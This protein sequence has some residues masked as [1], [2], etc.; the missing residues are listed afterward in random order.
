MLEM[1]QLMPAY[2]SWIRFIPRSFAFPGVEWV[3]PDSTL[4]MGEAWVRELGNWGVPTSDGS[5]PWISRKPVP[6]KL[7]ALRQALELYVLGLYQS[8]T[9]ADS[10]KSDVHPR[11]GLKQEPA[12]KVAGVRDGRCSST[13]YLAPI[14]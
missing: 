12:G 10:L 5:G 11:L 13:A 4:K 9:V 14:S 1:G 6:L 3:A 8:Y 7:P 2:L